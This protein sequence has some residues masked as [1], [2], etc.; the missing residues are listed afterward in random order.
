[1]YRLTGTESDAAM[2]M[3]LFFALDQ[4]GLWTSPASLWLGLLYCIVGYVVKEAS[5]IFGAT[6]RFDSDLIDRS[7]YLP[8]DKTSCWTGQTRVAWRPQQCDWHVQI[9]YNNTTILISSSAALF[10]PLLSDMHLDLHV[11]RLGALPIDMCQ[12]LL[13]EQLLL[14]WTI[15]RKSLGMEMIISIVIV[16]SSVTVTFLV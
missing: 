13:G 5:D 15:I 7:A 16:I 3:Q 2:N 12:S 9:L 8:D 11:D 6:H 4:H 1:M 14:R 10:L